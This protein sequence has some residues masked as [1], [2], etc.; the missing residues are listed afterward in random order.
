[1]AV[2]DAFKLKPDTK[3]ARIPRTL[4]L[5]TLTQAQ[6]AWRQAG[7]YLVDQV[8]VG[9]E[10]GRFVGMEDEQARALCALILASLFAGR[11]VKNFGGMKAL[12]GLFGKF[13]HPVTTKESRLSVMGLASS[14]AKIKV[15]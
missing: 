12:Q 6:T 2:V 5:A 7:S 15:Q 3:R 8:D 10:K 9:D 4:N 13:I 1:M 14:G 11:S